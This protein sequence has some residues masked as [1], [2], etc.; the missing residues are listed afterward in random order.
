MTTIVCQ[1]CQQ[2]AAIRMRQHRLALC[3]EHFLEWFVDQTQ[4]FIEKYH[5]FAPTDR[6][7][8][9]VSGGKDSLAL[10]DVL[11]RL[12]YQADG[13]YIHLGIDSETHY[14]QESERMCR[15]FAGERNLHL[16]VV[17]VEQSYG[18][19]IPHLA[20]KSRRGRGRPCAVC[21]LSKRHILN[22]A[23]REGGYDVLVTAHNLDDEVAV[24]F[25]NTMSWQVDQLNRQSPVLEGS[26]DGFV[27]KAKPFCRFYERETAAYTLLRGIE[28]IEEEC[29]FSVGSKQLAYKDLLN[30]LEEEHPGMKLSFYVNFLNAKRQGVF[31]PGA[32]EAAA[33]ELK[34]CPVCGS[35]TTNDGPCAFCKTVQAE[36]RE[37]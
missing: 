17:S 27:R 8:V 28:Y 25:G 36:K 10:W 29:P 26:E 21:G 19:T 24:L 3:S 15:Q 12:G 11:W 34:P 32:G 33:I 2:K 35:P 18:A 7:L 20:W 5:M 14:S 16:Q 23:A 31:T 22:Q 1:K 9:A 13:L 37:A 4:R 30:R 6:V